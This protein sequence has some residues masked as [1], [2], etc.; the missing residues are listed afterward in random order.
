METKYKYKS[1]LLIDDVD[2]DNFVSRSIITAFRFAE[3]VH[4]RTDVKSALTFLSEV[5]Q[6]PAMRF[7]EVIFIDINMPVMDG[8]QF[9]EIFKREFKNEIALVM[10]KLVILTS[11][12]FR[13][14]QQLAKARFE[15]VIFVVKPISEKILNLI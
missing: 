12:V 10:P 6:A 13:S 11:S 8:F 14:D 5:A 15:D 3:T 7:P 9:L 4:V 2:M 1:V